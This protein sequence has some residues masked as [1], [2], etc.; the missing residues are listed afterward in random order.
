MLNSPLMGLLQN[1]FFT[2]H[3]ADFL[4]ILELHGVWYSPRA[5]SMD[6]SAKHRSADFNIVFL[7]SKLMRISVLTTR[8]PIEHQLYTPSVSHKSPSLAPLVQKSL[9]LANLPAYR[10]FK[11]VWP[12]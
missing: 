1:N 3:I 11:N 2:S 12:F 6:C 4:L 8:L 5:E 10:H 9:R 7:S